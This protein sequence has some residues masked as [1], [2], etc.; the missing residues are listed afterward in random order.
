ML[1]NTLRDELSGLCRG[2]VSDFPHKFIIG[3]QRNLF[4]FYYTPTNTKKQVD[5]GEQ[6]FSCSSGR[7]LAK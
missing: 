2:N 3:P 1:L 4:L 5:Q 7:M 6:T